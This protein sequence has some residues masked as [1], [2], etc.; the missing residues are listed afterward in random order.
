MTLAHLYDCPCMHTQSTHPPFRNHK[1]QRTCRSVSTRNPSRAWRKLVMSANWPTLIVFVSRSTPKSTMISIGSASA[2]T[3][4]TTALHHRGLGPDAVLELL[5]KTSQAVQ[6]NR[7]LLE[8][9]LDNMLQGVAVIDPN[10]RL[11]GWNRAYL[12]LMDYPEDTVYL[13]QPIEEL[14][15]FNA[16]RGLIGNEEAEQAVRKR[17]DLLA[18]PLDDEIWIVRGEGGRALLGDTLAERGWRLA[19]LDSTIVAQA[20]RIGRGAHRSE[21]AAA[22]VVRVPGGET[23]CFSRAYRRVHTGW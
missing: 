2:R 20:P 7:E 12:E 8:A 22:A 16:E 21:P 5:D 23:Q 6:F 19:N 4:L 18:E 1:P 3:V 13:G 10:L 9:T 11:V 14:I 15:R 17:L